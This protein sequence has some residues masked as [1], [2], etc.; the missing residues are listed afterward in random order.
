MIVLPKHEQFD[1]FTLISL[2]YSLYEAFKKVNYNCSKLQIIVSA[3]LDE[4]KRTI[5]DIYHKLL[6]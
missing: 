6:L 4:N 2:S 5:Y 3:D 1:S